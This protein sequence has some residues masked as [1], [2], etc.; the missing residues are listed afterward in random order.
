MSDYWLKINNCEI[1]Q[2]C[3][4]SETV[5]SIFNSDLMYSHSLFSNL[6]RIMFHALIHMLFINNIQENLYKWMLWF[7]L[8]FEL[9]KIELLSI[10]NARIY[11]YVTPEASF[12]PT[13]V[14]PTQP[15]AGGVVS[16]LLCSKRCPAP[17]AVDTAPRAFPASLWP[18]V[19]SPVSS[20]H[21][22]PFFCPLLPRALHELL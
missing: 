4:F 8:L 17:S 18:L 1:L 14:H 3:T 13:A 9:Q 7:A 2:C 12:P 10:W 6:N 11:L 20:N 16:R 19:F 22:W 5:N 21:R 15:A